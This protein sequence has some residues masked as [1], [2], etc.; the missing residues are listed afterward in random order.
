M[1]HGIPRRTWTPNLMDETRRIEVCG[2]LGEN[3]TS[4]G[5]IVTRET[6]RQ[7]EREREREM[8]EIEV[9]RERVE[10]NRNERVQ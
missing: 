8:E 9:E 4:A 3:T 10:V 6:E 2:H 5:P 7:R 1:Q